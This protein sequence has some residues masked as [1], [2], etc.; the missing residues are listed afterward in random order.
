[1]FRTEVHLLER[2]KVKG[3]E[4]NEGIASKGAPS[5]ILHL[6]DPIS[7]RKYPALTAEEERISIPLQMLCLAIFDAILLHILSSV[8]KETWEGIR[9]SLADAFFI[10]KDKQ[11]AAIIEHTYADRDIIFLQEAAGSFVTNPD[12]GGILGEHYD[13]LTP[14]IL[15]T[16]RDQNSII[17]IRKGFLK[18]PAVEIT[19]AVLQSPPNSSSIFNPGDVA[20]FV[21]MSVSGQQFLIGSSCARARACVRACVC[22]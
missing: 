19:A 11:T 3:N 6:L 10:N 16:K 17:L 13:I 9:R 8:G 5:L 21:C 7:A 20:A 1:M 4:G 18:C 2:G 15:D 12:A 14:A 22:V